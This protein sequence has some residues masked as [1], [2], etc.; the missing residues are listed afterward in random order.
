M[1]CEDCG[2]EMREKLLDSIERHKEGLRAT[3][4]P[5]WWEGDPEGSPYS[6]L[7][8]YHMHLTGL[9]RRDSQ[10]LAMQDER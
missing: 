5:A 7:S 10:A 2:K 3:K 4:V 8:A 9:L 6:R 1:K